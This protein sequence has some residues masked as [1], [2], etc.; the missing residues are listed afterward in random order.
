MIQ[1]TAP[2][3]VSVSEYQLKRVGVYSPHVVGWKMEVMPLSSQNSTQLQNIVCSLRLIFPIHSSELRVSG[4]KRFIFEAYEHTLYR[5]I[6]WS[7][8]RENLIR[9]PCYTLQMLEWRP[10][11]FPSRL[12]YVI[13]LRKNLK[14]ES[15][16]ESQFDLISYPIFP[17]Y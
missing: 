17:C 8:I 2:S 9:A 3:L 14:P 5:E 13:I 15:T 1:L 7:L 12:G 6:V 11:P 4:R 10:L 16:P